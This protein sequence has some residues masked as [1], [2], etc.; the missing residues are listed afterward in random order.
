VATL[1]IIELTR[2]RIAWC[3]LLQTFHGTEDVGSYDYSCRR[4]SH[5]VTEYAIVRGGHAMIRQNDQPDIHFVDDFGDVLSFADHFYP[6]DI[7][8]L[9]KEVVIDDAH[10]PILYGIGRVIQESEEVF[11]R[12]P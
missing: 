4:I 8:S 7:H 1:K 6:V 11:G 2:R 9:G 3:K 5:G 12:P 10:G